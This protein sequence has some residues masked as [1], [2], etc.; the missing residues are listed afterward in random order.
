MRDAGAPNGVSDG[1]RDGAEWPSRVIVEGFFGKEQQIPS[2]L[3]GGLTTPIRA[4]FAGEETFNVSIG[5][6]FAST[7]EIWT[8][9]RG[10]E[11]IINAVQSVLVRSR[12][13][14]D[15]ARE[16]GRGFDPYDLPF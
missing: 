3:N 6:G 5:T 11:A 16:S 12:I 1:S 4:H 8:D 13:A 10:M 7:F 2:A 9:E 15:K 14:L